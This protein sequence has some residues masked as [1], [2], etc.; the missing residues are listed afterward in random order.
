MITGVVI[1]GHQLAVADEVEVLRI[2]AQGVIAGQLP[3][4]VDRGGE[5]VTVGRVDFTGQ[6]IAALGASRRYAWIV[7]PVPVV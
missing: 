2:D 4:G 3:G 6:R 1:K 5:Q 7:V